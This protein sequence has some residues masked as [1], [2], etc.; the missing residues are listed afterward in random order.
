MEH[1]T[2]KIVTTTIQDFLTSPKEFISKLIGEKLGRLVIKLNDTELYLSTKEMFELFIRLEIRKE[3]VIFE[4]KYRKL[5]ERFT[6]S[7]D[8]V[9]IGKL[10]KAQ[11]AL[12]Q[13]EQRFHLFDGLTHGELLSV[14][15]SIKIIR[16]ERGEKV[17]LKGNTTKEMFF[18]VGGGVDILINDSV[19]ASLPKG[20]FFGEMSYITNKPRS[21]TAIIKTPISIVLSFT[22]KENLDTNKSEAF[23]KL[24]KNINAML[25]DKIEDM[26]KKLYK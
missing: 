4:E 18:V 6:K 20:S 16:M 9:D 1:K 7:S 26:N 21:A 23:M 24:F 14:V 10:T 12:I 22:I 25:V 19:I 5:K 15:E 2:L 3:R 17:F 13:L 8:K 11:Q